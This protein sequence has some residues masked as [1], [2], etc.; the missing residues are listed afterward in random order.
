MLALLWFN[1]YIELPAIADN[2]N[3]PPIADNANK[4]PIA[5]SSNK[6][7]TAGDHNVPDWLK[8]YDKNNFAPSA[9][10]ATATPATPASVHDAVNAPSMTT[11]APAASVDPGATT[12]GKQPLD[13]S[14]VLPVRPLTPLTAPGQPVEHA[15]APRPTQTSTSS[16]TTDRATDRANSPAKPMKML[17]GRLEEI[18]G[19]GASLPVGVMLKL[20]VQ[21]AKSDPAVTPAA[22]PL[23]GQVASFPMDWRGVWGGQLKIHSRQASKLAYQT[24]YEETTTQDKILVPGTMGS[25]N[26]NFSQRGRDIFLEPAQIMLPQRTDT[27]QAR[28]TQQQLKA[29]GLEQMLGGNSSA[30]L[31]SMTASIP[32]LVL[33]QISNARG[34]TGNTFSSQVLKNDIRELKPGVLEQ[35]L[36]A[37][38]QETKT[39]T[40]SVEHYVT[41]TVIRFTKLNQNQL[42][43]QAASVQYRKDGQFESK[44]L[45]Y[46][47]VNRGQ[48]SAGPLPGAFPGMPASGGGGL[49]DLNNLLKNL[50]GF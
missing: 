41:E 46:G 7:A 23:Q 2:A 48:A 19:N 47:T 1:G 13:S 50:Q 33:G 43:V 15:A 27:A 30:L 6:P 26:F 38:T 25:V 22:K 40:G 21:S 45:M 28:A 44:V 42:Y 32:V 11:A 31:Q 24:D 18:G 29:L 8:Q 39:K 36:V 34:V 9:P 37:Q 5:D 14:A 4:P 20:K 12:A 49:G 3:K 17:T 10:S 16:K 35:N